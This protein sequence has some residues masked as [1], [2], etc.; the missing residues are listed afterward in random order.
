MAKLTAT[1]GFDEESECIEYLRN[2]G[3]VL[4]QSGQQLMLDCK[5]S[6]GKVKEFTP[7]SKDDELGVTHGSV[8]HSKNQDRQ[9]TITHFL[10]K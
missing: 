5:A 10:R 1:I 9:S 4:R 2:T 3:C 8:Y 6:R 7:K